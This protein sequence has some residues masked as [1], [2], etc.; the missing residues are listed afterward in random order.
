MP[1]QGNLDPQLLVAGG[2][3][4]EQGVEHVLRRSTARRISSISATASR[5]KRR[6]KNVAELVRLVKA[7]MS[8]VP[9][10]DDGPSPER[11]N[12]ACASMT[13]RRVAI[14][15]F[16]LGGPDEQKA[17]RPFLFNLFNDKAIIGAPQPFR[18]L[19]AQLISPLAREAGESKLRAHGR[20][21]AD[22]AGNRETSGGAGK[23]RSPSASTT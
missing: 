10:E 20:R 21:F 11:T 12:R 1:L 16:N 3:F 6:R 8:A 22:P 5:R 2:K 18:F 23:P 4:L 15:L 9:L 19:I 13:S 17:V 14:I 7:R